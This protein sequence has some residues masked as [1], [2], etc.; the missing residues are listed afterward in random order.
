MRI[1]CGALLAVSLTLSACERS[2]NLGLPLCDSADVSP[3]VA[4]IV[5]AREAM[6]LRPASS[7]DLSVTWEAICVRLSSVEPVALETGAWSEAVGDENFAAGSYASVWRKSDEAWEL[8]DTLKTLE[9]CG[10]TL[11]P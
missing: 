10:G 9:G 3:D 1:S 6:N 5:A 7:G 11:C 2:E 4:G 8:T